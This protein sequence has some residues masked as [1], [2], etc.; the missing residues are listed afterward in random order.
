MHVIGYVKINK[1]AKFYRAGFLDKT[2]GNYK[3]NEFV[4]KNLQ[5]RPTMTVCFT[6][7]CRTW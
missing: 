5:K 4:D 7:L 2:H 6:S 1:L 3:E